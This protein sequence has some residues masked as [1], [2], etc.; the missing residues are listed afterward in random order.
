MHMNVERTD[1]RVN[2]EPFGEVSCIKFLRTQVAADGGCEIDVGHRM[3][4]RYK[5]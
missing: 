1:V 4:E 5:I 3:N 2:D